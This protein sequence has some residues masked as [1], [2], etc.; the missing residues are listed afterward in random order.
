MA[1]LNIKGD[2]NS[3]NLVYSSPSAGINGDVDLSN[4]KK[5]IEKLNE[6]MKKNKLIMSVQNRYVSMMD[7]VL[8]QMDGDR[9]ASKFAEVASEAARVFPEMVTPDT[10]YPTVY[11]FMNILDTE[12][13]YFKFYVH[14]KYAAVPNSMEVDGLNQALTA[15]ADQYM[16]ILKEGLLTQS[17]DVTYI[18]PPPLKPD[19]TPD[20]DSKT[21]TSALIWVRL[22]NDTAYTNYTGQEDYLWGVIGTGIPD[23]LDYKKLEG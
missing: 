16:P 1:N 19:G 20:P 22:E 13:T 4:I 6:G 23:L 12:S 17:V 5:E 18:W 11:T 15:I 21:K 2:T 8:E 14:P 10:K 9:T 7:Y 3:T